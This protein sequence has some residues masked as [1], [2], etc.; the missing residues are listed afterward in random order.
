MK[1]ELPIS[2]MFYSIQCEGITN[3]YPAYFIRLK[4]CNLLCGNPNMRGVKD[5]TNQG[6]IEK[7]QD[8]KA[9]WVCDTISVWL[10]GKQTPY[11]NIIDQWEKEGELEYILDGR[12]HVIWTGGE[13]T[14]HDSTIVN[15]M[16]H[17]K[18]QFPRSSPF[19][20]IETNGTRELSD[21]LFERIDQINCSPKLGNSGMPLERRVNPNALTQI[22]K[23]PNSWFKYV[24][25][26]E[27]DLIE[28]QR[29]MIEPLYL[30]RRRIILMPGLSAQNQYFERTKFCYELAKKHH[31][32]GVSRGHISAWNKKT[33][34]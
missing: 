6:E 23:H 13:P 2:E 28:A 34:V 11:Q 10:Q 25:S 33:G 1:N 18:Q 8:P 19:Y 21:D 7:N 29:D 32:I 22:N 31:Y 9:T 3:G 27:Q 30:N 14:I 5:K 4:G 17:L 24:V 16:N 26:S 12:T 15:F 20:E